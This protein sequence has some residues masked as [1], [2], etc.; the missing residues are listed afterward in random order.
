MVSLC[1]QCHG[2]QLRDYRRAAH[3]GATGYWDLSRGPRTRNLCITCHD[4]HTPAYV[5]GLPVLPPRDRF[6]DWEGNH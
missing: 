6:L 4:P 5:G 1:G 3:G 2:P